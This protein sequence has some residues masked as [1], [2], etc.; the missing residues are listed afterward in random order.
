MTINYTHN[1][2]K[3][4]YELLAK[5]ILEFRLP[6]QYI[7]L[8]HRDRPDL[9]C[10][11]NNIGIEVSR[12]MFDSFEDVNGIFNRYKGK[13]LSDVKSK[14]T[15]YL[16]DRGYQ[17]LAHKGI[18]VGYCPKV[19]HWVTLNPLK[20]IFNSK[21]EKLDKYTKYAENDLFI[22]GPMFDEYDTRDIIEFGQWIYQQ[23]SQ[24]RCCYDKVYIFD[25]P[26]LYLYDYSTNKL[27]NF[28][29][30]KEALR[31]LCKEAYRLCDKR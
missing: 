19:A 12:S 10:V 27:Q 28:T 8:E 25:D 7:N 9:Y 17:L 3:D 30:P 14:D 20:K 26:I 1:S 5:L 6:D 2:K 23:Q 29:I 31:E 11:K 18:V 24:S 22:F 16:N 4:Y 15:E 13:Y 21:L